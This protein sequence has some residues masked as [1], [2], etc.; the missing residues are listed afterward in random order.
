[1]TRPGTFV[2]VL[3]IVVALAALRAPVA[4]SAPAPTLVT[5][6]NGLRVVLAP[7]SDATAADV[8]VWYPVNALAEGTANVGMRHLVERLMYRG[9]AATPDGEF[10]RR[11]SAEGATLNTALTADYTCFWQTVPGPAVA[12]ALRLE[13]DRMA[14][15]QTS[16]AAFEE[17]RRGSLGDIRARATRPLLGR[18]VSRLG[19][20]VYAGE[21]LARPLEGDE[22]SLGRCTPAGVE[23]WRRAHYRAG[24]AV[25]T[26]VGRFEPTA[27]LE[28]VRRL[29]EPL[30]RG[31]AS[32]VPA[33]PA[34]SAGPHRDWARTN[35]PARL[36]LAGWRV[37]GANDPDY[38]AVELLA[39]VLGLGED[40]RLSH[41]LGTTWHVASDAACGLDRHRDAS[42]FWVLAALAPAADTANAQRVLLDQVGALARETL[43][44]PD[45]DRARAQMLTGE[46]FRLQ[47]ARARA[48]VLGEAVLSTGDLGAAERRLAALERL[49]PADLQRVA[50]R[51]FTDNARSIVWLVPAGG[52]R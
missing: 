21:A 36:L 9:T 43:P 12:L 25:L 31:T 18:A 42:M 5:L 30:P 19:E 47:T 4:H 49:T 7:D 35:T 51:I 24:D 20:S 32:A 28:L 33:A 6:K 48:Q 34:A 40:S 15:L 1:M 44:G 27:T 38:P 11:L 16:P 39:G 50:Q 14:G 26:I 3:A 13:A 10:V 23:A 45:V 17:A 37:P 29:F 41:A 52:V 46:L 22:G 2:A 8:A